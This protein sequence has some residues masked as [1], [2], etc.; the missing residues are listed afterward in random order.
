MYRQAYESLKNWQNKTNRKPLVIKGARQVGK[1]WL[2]KHFGEECYGNMIYIN[3]DRNELAKDIF[4]M[5]YDPARIITRLSVHTQ[6]EKP[7]LICPIYVR[8]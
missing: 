1:T 6:Q 7:R 4:A 8:L 3:F 2:V 5:D